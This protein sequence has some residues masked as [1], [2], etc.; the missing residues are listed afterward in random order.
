MKLP[1]HIQ[2]LI[3]THKEK[4]KRVILVYGGLAKIPERTR[5]ILVMEDRNREQVIQKAFNEHYKVLE[6]AKEFKEDWDFVPQWKAE[7]NK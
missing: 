6:L 3:D 5:G 7:E 1:E 4:R 2:E